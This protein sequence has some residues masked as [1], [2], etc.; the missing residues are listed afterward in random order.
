MP[1]DLRKAHMALDKAVDKLYRLEPFKNDA[2]RVALLLSR[3]E[4]LI[5][6]KKQSA[7]FKFLTLFLGWFLKDCYAATI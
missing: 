5:K 1:P 2:E 6:K 7:Q 3:Y 4:A